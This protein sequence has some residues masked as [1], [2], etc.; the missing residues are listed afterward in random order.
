MRTLKA[1]T[2][3]DVRDFRVEE[4]RRPEIASPSD[5]LLQIRLGAICGSD[6]HIYH[7]HTPMDPGATVGHEVVG[8]VEETGAAVTSVQPG[9]RVIAAFY[10]ACG[11]CRQ[12]RRGWW[13]QCETRMIFGHGT[14]FGGLGGAQAEYLLVPHADVNLA[15]IPDGVEDEQAILVGDVLATGMFAAERGGIQPGDTVAVIGAGP[16]GLSAIMCAELFGPARVFAVDMVGD[17]LEMAADLGALPLDSRSVS[18]QVEIQRHT[19]GLGADVVL[20][21][22]GRMEAIQTAID[23]ARGGGTVSSVGV[24][25]QVTADFPYWEFWTRDLSFR[26]GCANVHAYMRPLLEL[27]AA[28]RLRPER[29]I[30]H[31]MPLA[32]AARAYKMFDRREATKIVLRP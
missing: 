23:C 8:V 32:E 26:S 18:P 15:V 11:H 22:V 31:R 20:E 7:G 4:V 13:A 29:I 25:S 27:I 16:V 6:L 14:Y 30:S 2:F 12:C 10:V 1:V 28:G 17:R 19:G 3:H 5:A 24:P 21:C 9:D